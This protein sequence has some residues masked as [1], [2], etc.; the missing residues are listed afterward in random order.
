MPVNCEGLHRALSIVCKRLSAPHEVDI[1]LIIENALDAR[2][3]LICGNT[4]TTSH[5]DASSIKL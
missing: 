5:N 2:C 1:V 4:F 3:I